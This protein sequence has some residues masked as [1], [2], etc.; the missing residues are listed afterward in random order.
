MTER[1]GYEKNSSAGDNSGNSRNEKTALPENQSATIE[2]PREHAWT[3]EPII[4][5]EQER[6][7]SLFNDWTMYGTE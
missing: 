5:P 6:H 7:S 3:F 1:L 2:V 4:V